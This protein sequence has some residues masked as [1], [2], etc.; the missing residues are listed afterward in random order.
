VTPP[1][2]AH[3]HQSLLD[4]D[5][6]LVALL[7]REFEHVGI[8]S[9]AM[10][11][12]GPD[13]DRT[14]MWPSPT[15]NL[16]LYDI[17]ESEVARDRSWHQHSAE[18]GSVMRRGALRLDCSYA[19]TAWTKSVVDEHRLLSQVLSIL[20]AYPALP[21]EVLAG[22]L[23]VGDPP[24]A[25]PTQV[26]HGRSEGRADFWTA[27]GSA[28]KLSLE[29]QVTVFVMPSQQQARGPQVARA[30][31]ALGSSSAG[32]ESL[33]QGGVVRFEDGRP[34]DGAVVVI[35]ALGLAALV[36]AAGRFTLTGVTPGSHAGLVREADGGAH[37]VTVAAPGPV[38]SLVIPS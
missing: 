37:P 35:P 12:E 20:L 25:L 18:S 16:F 21:P 19:I 26:A 4:L 9:V 8:T 23:L 27:I 36:D 14:A 33:A 10:T 30:G 13:R 34:T 3:A 24:M 28:Y 6:A 1:S 7:T 38:V 17:R 32:E 15:V 29:Y 11:F 31:V 22:D 5:E 2:S